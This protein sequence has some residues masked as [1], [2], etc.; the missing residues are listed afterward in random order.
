MLKNIVNM[1]RIKFYRNMESYDINLKELKNMQKAGAEIIDVRSRAEFNEGHL[2]GAINIPE[3]ELKS[4]FKK[5]NIDRDKVIVVY[6]ISGYRSKRA[7]MKLKKMG[8]NNVYNLYG[9]LD[10]Y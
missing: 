6:C 2:D 8:Y 1:I 5:L 7:Y 9:G 3:Y 4:S 10:E